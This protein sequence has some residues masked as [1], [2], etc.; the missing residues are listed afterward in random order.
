MVPNT[1]QALVQNCSADGQSGQVFDG[2]YP[3]TVSPGATQGHTKLTGYVFF[4]NGCDT[5][6]RVFASRKFTLSTQPFGTPLLAEGSLANGATYAA[7]GLVP[8]SWAQVKGSALSS[9]T[10][11]W[12]GADFTGLGNRLPTALSGVQ[13]MVNNTAAAVYY[14]DPGQV[15]FQVPAGITGTASVQVIDNGLTSSPIT[16]AAAASS[17]GIFPVIVNGTNYA[18]GVFL[19]GK[20]V[21]DPTVSPAFRNAKPGDVIQLYATGLTATPAGVLPTPQDVSGVTVTLGGV[22]IP[23]DFAGL[24]AVGEFQI[25]FTVPPGFANRPAG[26]YPITIAVNGVSSPAT[27]GTSPAAAVVVPITP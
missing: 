5:G 11:I 23:A 24:V 25:N 15:S 20:F 6:P 19:D 7:G 8:G 13:V 10:R 14:I 2:W 22:T 21:G 12:G 16:A 17:P 27:I 4:Q 1:Q 9:V 18:A 3:S 26:T